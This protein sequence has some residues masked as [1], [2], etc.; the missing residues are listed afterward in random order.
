MGK[1]VTR[2]FSA[3]ERENISLIPSRCSAG[4]IAGTW[5]D[6]TRTPDLLWIE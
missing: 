6:L 4:L 2:L 5:Q 1:A 3:P